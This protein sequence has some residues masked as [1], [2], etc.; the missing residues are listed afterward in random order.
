[1]AGENDIIE[2][3]LVGSEEPKAKLKKPKD[4]TVSKS[5]LFRYKFWVR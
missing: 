1:M 2:E 5:K 3:A 4:A